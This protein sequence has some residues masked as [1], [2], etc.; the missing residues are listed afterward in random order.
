M[1]L[2]NTSV[3][4]IQRPTGICA[5]TARKLEPGEAY[6]AALVETDTESP[7]ESTTVAAANNNR[8]TN[9]QKPLTTVAG[10]KRIDVSA[11]AWDKGHKPKSVFSHWRSTIPHPHE[12]KKQFV[13]DEV[14]INLLDRFAETNQPDRLAF[15]FVLALILMRKKL[16]KYDGSEPRT[17]DSGNTQEWWHMRLKFNGD[18]RSIELLKPTAR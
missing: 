2:F 1:P 6:V 8:Q 14:L 7:T 10:F 16:L 5:I 17:L 18:E 3:Y 11:D 4:D 12:K 9:T 15:R 13:D